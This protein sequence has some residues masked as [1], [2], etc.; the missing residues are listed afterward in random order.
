MNLKIREA[1][2]DD[3]SDIS[4][5]V[6]EVHDLH[7]KNR[8]DIFLDSDNPFLKKQFEGLLNDISTKLFVAEDT[9][10][11]ELIAYSIVQIMIPKDIQIL[12]PSKFAYIHDFCV[13]STHQKK[14]VGKSLFRYITDYTKAENVSSVQLTEWEFNKHAVEFYES[15]GMTTMSRRMELKL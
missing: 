7:V 4:N 2:A 6:I 13:K 14:G 3:Y 11:R 15:L 1:V 10:S 8:P 9:D 5:L 12:I